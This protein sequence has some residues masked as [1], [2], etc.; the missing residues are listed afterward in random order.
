MQYTQV[1]R[2]ASRTVT[3]QAIGAFPT[4][5][6]KSKKLLLFA[7]RAKSSVDNLVYYFYHDQVQF[8]LGPEI[9][10]SPKIFGS[11]RCSSPRR[12]LTEGEEHHRQH[13]NRMR[14]SKIT[15]KTT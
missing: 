13:K 6:F 5:I 14:F 15:N 11:A 9:N 8:T 4:A 7:F 12:N 3:I 1:I 10:Q 2:N